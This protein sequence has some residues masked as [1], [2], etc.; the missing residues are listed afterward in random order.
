MYLTTKWYI[1]PQIGI[2]IMFEIGWLM[3]G[4]VSYLILKKKK[5]YLFLANILKLL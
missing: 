1:P 3:W 5:N 2:R 4:C